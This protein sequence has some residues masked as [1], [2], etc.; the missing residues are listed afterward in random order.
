[1]NWLTS[2]GLPLV[3]LSAL[4]LAGCDKG[5]DLNV[6]LPNTTVV[7]TEYTDFNVDAATVQIVPVQSQKTDHYLAG[8]VT[9]NVVGSLKATSYLNLITSY[10]NDS[11]P[12]KILAAG[13]IPVLDSVVLVAGFDKV[14]GTTTAPVLFDVSNLQAPLDERLAYSSNSIIPLTATPLGRNMPSRL[15]RTLRIRT[16]A[17]ATT[18]EYYTTVADQTVR[19]VMYRAVAVVAPYAP[20]PAVAS[21]F[22]KDTL[23]AALKTATR[24]S[25]TQLDGLLNGLAIAPSTGYSGSIV[26]FTSGYKGHLVF[27][28]HDDN[29]P[30]P[31]P[32]FTRKWHSYL[33]FF[34]PSFS[35]SSG[36]GTARDPRYF[37][38]IGNDFRGTALSLLADRTQAV[39]STQ[40]DGKSYLQ[41]GVG[42]GTRVTFRGLEALRATPGLTINRAELYVPVKP[43]S[44]V[45][46]LNA[47]QVFALEVDAT[48]TVLQ[49]TINY[50]PTDRVVQADGAN[51]LGTGSPAF[52][53][54]QNATS[55]QPSYTLL[56][57]SY[58][59]AYLTDKLEGNPASLVIVPAIRTSASLTLNRATVDAANIRLRVYYSKR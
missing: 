4:A 9:D 56:L 39:S 10:S 5:T 26:N 8:R 50:L 36:A 16:A 48:N 32:P 6:D 28:F 41:E 54:L 25:Q 30:A 47:N 15:D 31:T 13:A 2:R 43:F 3:A 34:G 29:I 33:V 12:A 35:S 7:S 44:N 59:Q 1:M 49:R 45:L 11:L 22:F 23:F 18:P 17:T 57:T 20:A 14:N 21:P 46:F 52:T 51:P 58:L 40:L 55:S 27:Y 37:T 24:F 42:I 19:L 38:Y 53:S